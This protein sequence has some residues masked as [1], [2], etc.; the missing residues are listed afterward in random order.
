MDKPDVTKKKV[1]REFCSET[2]VLVWPFSYVLNGFGL[3]KHLTIQLFQW[4]IIYFNC[5][6]D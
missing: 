3:R 1:Y 4:I 5:F 2:Q 6:T